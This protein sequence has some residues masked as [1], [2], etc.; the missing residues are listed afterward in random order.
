MIGLRNEIDKRMKDGSKQLTRN[1]PISYAYISKIINKT[2]N[3]TKTK[4]KKGK[5]TVQEAL[6]IFNELNFKTKDKFEAFIY[7]FTEQGE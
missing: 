2:Y 1:E 6:N 5:F 7:L 3:A 4:V